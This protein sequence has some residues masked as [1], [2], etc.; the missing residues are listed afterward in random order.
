MSGRS[1]EAPPMV[2]ES[3]SH[4]VDRR[5]RRHVDTRD[6]IV[7]EAIDII[8]TLGVGGLS[9][10]EIARRIGVRTPSIYTYVDSKADLY[11][12]LFRRGWQ[13]CLDV[14]VAHLERLGPV[15]PE[16][17]PLERLHVLAE[18]MVRWSLDNPGLGQ[19]MFFRP[20]PAWQPGEAAFAPS[21]RLG[22]ILLEE[23]RQYAMHGLLAPGGD[24]E[25]LLDHL[26]SAGAGVI[27]RQLADEPGTPYPSGRASRHFPT[28]VDAVCRP[29]LREPRPP[30]PS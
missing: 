12:E 19:L 6:L 5:R 17:D 7:A 15:T 9:L 14:V 27:A 20:V 23:A 26:T 3:S 10:G 4:R 29:H 16:S 24:P 1:A 30:E 22:E 21:V 25:V 28:L 11:D 8:T 13:E 2:G 18:A